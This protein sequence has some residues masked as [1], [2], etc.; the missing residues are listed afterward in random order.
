VLVSGDRFAARYT[1][2]AQMRK[3]ATLVN[4]VYMLGQLAADRRTRRLDSI[5]RSITQGQ[6]EEQRMRGTGAVT[7][8]PRDAY[9]AAVWRLSGAG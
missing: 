8:Y 6:P 4:E 3:G 2:H 9:S 1:V 7:T 5:T